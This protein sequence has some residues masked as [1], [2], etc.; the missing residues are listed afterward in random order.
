M[1]LEKFVFEDKNVKKVFWPTQ[2]FKKRAWISDEKIYDAAE[3]NP[4]K[5]WS[6]AAAE[7]DWF[8]KWKEVYVENPPYFKWFIDGKL[9]ASVNAVD[10]HLRTRKNK[11]AIIWES[12]VEEKN[13][14]LTYNDLY[15]A[16]NRLANVLKTFGIRKG[17]RVAIYLPLIPE[18]QIA[19][20][21]CARIGAIH[22]IIFSA[23]S[24]EALRKRIADAGAKLLI[25]ADGYYRRGKSV[26]L[27]AAADLAVENT[28][29]ERVIVV[30]RLGI[31]VTMRKDRDYWWNEL[32]KEA[33]SFCEP[34]VMDSEDPLFIL[35]TSG[36]T[37]KPKG[38]QH[39]TGGYLVQANIT[40]KWDFNLH[41]ED[42][43]WCT[44]DIGWV[45]GHT[46]ACYGPLL[47]GATFLIYEGAPDYP[48]PDRWW[49]IIEKYKVTVLYTAPTAIRT[50]IKLGEE[51]AKKHD[52]SSLK[53]LG[54]VG[55]PIDRETWLWYFKNIGYERCPV[56]DTWWQT[57]TGGTLIHALPG[58]GPFIP[59][60]AG[61]SFPGTKHTV[62][63]EKG[64]PAKVNETGY[65]V[66][67]SPFAP[68]MLR[69][70]W[71]DPER[72]KETYWSKFGDRIYFTG[73]G[74][75]MDKAG[76]FRLTG[77]VDDVMKVAGHRL[78]NAEIE[79]A[80]NVHKAV[81]ESAVVSMPHEIKGEVPIAFV[82]LKRGFKPSD[83]LALELIKH[84]ATKISPIAKPEKI[85]FVRDLPTTRSGKIMR[86]ILRSIVRKEEIGDATTLMNPESVEEIK[87][88]VS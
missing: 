60:F 36:T 49:E 32:I 28:T 70:I 13:R 5:F 77:R 6:K 35:Y 19:M 3:K 69:G 27:K 75:K 48:Q 4:L 87:K 52:L 71:R 86:R 72:Y 29:I 67:L 26:N 7:I 38:I 56:I 20:L 66:Q 51:W 81:A 61:R 31:A 8:K 74:A 80:L 33:K 76:N 1:K 88:L 83:A 55:E 65:L 59:A 43:F 40:A 30:K 25:T 85:F 11:P 46:Y 18:V 54:T 82:L 45:T 39:S 17:D 57:E 41:Y 34:E 12:E 2:A 63:N 64:G 50:F 84:V 79:E 44:S 68:G 10:R 14:I 23:F 22:S 47:N 53:I 37:G 78:A 24:P 73:D 62:L 9:N 42:I 21:A 58:I 16:V 15:N